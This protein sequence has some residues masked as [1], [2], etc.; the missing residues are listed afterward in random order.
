[1]TIPPRWATGPLTRALARA[2]AGLTV[3]RRTRRYSRRRGLPAAVAALTLGVT[4]GIVVS[5]VPAPDANAA[6]SCTFNVATQIVNDCMGRPAGPLYR[7][8]S[9]TSWINGDKGASTSGIFVSDGAYAVPSTTADSTGAWRMAIAPHTDAHVI[10]ARLKTA[11]TGAGVFA[12]TGTGANQITYDLYV[13][14]GKYNLDRTANGTTTSVYSQFGTAA[15]GNTIILGLPSPEYPVV[16]GSA[17]GVIKTSYQETTLQAANTFGIESGSVA[18]DGTGKATTAGTTTTRISDVNIAVGNGTISDAS[19]AVTSHAVSSTTTVTVRAVVPSDI[20]LARLTVGN[21]PATTQGSSLTGWGTPTSPTVKVTHGGTTS[22]YSSDY[23]LTPSPAPNAADFSAKT[24]AQAHSLSAGD[25]VTASFDIS[26]PATAGTFQPVIALWNFS[27]TIHAGST[28]D[29]YSGRATN[30]VAIGA[31]GCAPL[32]TPATGSQDNGDAAVDCFTRG[33]PAADLNGGSTQTG[34]TTWAGATGAFGT[35]AGDTAVP[36]VAPAQPVDVTID[37]TAST[38]W[39]AQRGRQAASVT[40]TLARGGATWAGEGLS[41]LSNRSSTALKTTAIRIQGSRIEAV[42]VSGPSETVIASWAFPAGLTP[43]AAS[44]TLN[45]TAY[46][47]ATSFTSQAWAIDVTANGTNVGRFDLGTAA[48]DGYGFGLYATTGTPTSSSYD[49]F[50][51]RTAY[52]GGTTLASSTTTTGSATT[53]DGTTTIGTDGLLYNISLPTGLATVSSLTW[54]TGLAAGSFSTATSTWTFTT[55]QYVLAGQRISWRIA[56]TNDNT[57]G[58]H[59]TVTVTNR[60]TPPTALASGTPLFESSATTNPWYA[61]R[62]AGSLTLAVDGAS[63]SQVA[64]TGT[65]MALTFTGASTTAVS[66][67]TLALP[68]G[69]DGSSATVTTSGL[70]AGTATPSIS[71]DRVVI[72]LS[73]PTNLNASPL[74]FTISGLTTPTYA[75]KYTASGTSRDAAGALLDAATSSPVTF[76]GAFASTPTLKIDGTNQGTTKD[77]SAAWT[78]NV[79]TKAAGTL[80]RIEVALPAGTTGTPTLS[81]ITGFQSSLTA[82]MSSGALELTIDTPYAPDPG[83]ALSLTITGLSP[84]AL[85]TATNPADVPVTT[86]NSSTVGAG[87]QLDATGAGTAPQVSIVDVWDVNAT[88]SSSSP[89]TGRAATYTYNL[90]LPVRT[91]IKSFSVTLPAGTGTTGWAASQTGLPGTWST[92]LSGTKITWTATTPTRTPAG[93]TAVTLTISGVTN[94]STSGSQQHAISFV[95]NEDGAVHAT[96]NPTLTLM[97]PTVTVTAPTTVALALNPSSATDSRTDLAVN[98]TSNIGYTLTL[99]AT[100]MTDGAGHTLNGVTATS[101][102]SQNASYPFSTD[103]YG[104][105]LTTVP[106]GVTAPAKLTGDYTTPPSPAAQVATRTNAGNDDYTFSLGAHTGWAQLAGAY[107][108]TLTFT[109]TAN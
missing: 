78:L 106:A 33:T 25:I 107:S 49:D 98:V 20:S 40:A 70:P 11:G 51:V 15:D 2:R 61:L 62:T 83:T 23:Q 93:A 82:S 92:A 94:T 32:D 22:D 45:A 81:N 105:K 109:V 41:V 102:L 36:A 99:A 10:R 43:S 47:Y 54:S 34:G 100:P 37:P 97:T 17:G 76:T 79:T 28:D 84:T 53:I 108:S 63:T 24:Q 8:S 101:D 73:T 72:A 88:V 42:R 52:T 6:I 30:V 80:A 66:T 50:I 90:T 86:W 1:M 75:G 59:T 91:T 104:I 16:Y 56:G 27:G 68:Q 9:G 89:Y 21:G 64:K 5:S 46:P 74:T 7:T 14:G 77:T 4:S 96:G 55:P 58:P 44:L 12:T 29:E 48:L 39:P 65:T 103:A 71:G 57:V 87:T 69:T 67:I 31:T 26:T 19:W 38:V 85:G 18:V 95:Q 3:T 35:T 13:S 60:G